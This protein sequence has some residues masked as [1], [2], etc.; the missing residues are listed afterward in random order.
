MTPEITTSTVGHNEPAMISQATPRNVGEDERVYSILAGVGLALYGF[1]RGSWFGAA[2]MLIGAS[3]LDR[4]WRGY[5][6]AYDQ[7]GIS[8]ASDH[9]S[10][11]GV[12]AQHGRKVEAVIHIDRDRRDI[13][14]FWRNLENLPRVMR[15][16]KSVTPIN[17]TRSKWVA[18][19][20]L[21]KTLQWEAEI[22][23]DRPGEVIAWQSV[24]GSQ[25]D[26][27][28]SVHLYASPTGSG[29][30]IVV[31]LKYDPPGGHFVDRLAHLFGVALEDDLEE[32]LLALKKTFE[33]GGE[34]TGEGIQTSEPSETQSL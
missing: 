4:G 9:R 11:P 24:P 1:R 8:T 32:D 23:N 27:A 7:L 26:T 10:R 31:S 21:A 2:S 3:L 12:R 19:A 34:A 16:L 28:G 6:A 25:V 15:H 18:Y 13:Y 5:C 33:G 20:P 14:D 29:T 30:N 17:D 22:I